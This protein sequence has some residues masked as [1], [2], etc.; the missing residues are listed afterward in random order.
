MSSRLDRLL[1]LLDTGSSTSVR[2]TAAKQLAQL[3]AKSVISD[4]A[5]EEDVKSARPNVPRIDPSGWSELM[6]VVARILPYLHS[7]SHDTRTAASVALSHIFTLV[8]LWC[9][10]P[11]TDADVDMKPP[12]DFPLPEFPLFSVHELMQKGT[13]LLASSGK[14]FIKP[15]GILQS[16]AEVK[17]ARKEAMSRM[18]LD[19]LESVGGTD[20]MDIDK[21]LVA[22]EAEMDVDEVNGLKVE[23]ELKPSPPVDIPE[24]RIKEESS[25]PPRP[26]SKSPSAPSPSTSDAPMTEEDMS[27]LSARERNRLKRKRKPGNN[28]FVAAPPP[29]PQNSS[30]KYSAA[31]AGPSGK[32]RLVAN[33]DQPARPSSRVN[34]PH[35]PSDEGPSDKVVVDPSKG[36]AVSPKAAQQSKALEVQPGCWIWDG[37]VKIL[38][39]D[40][41]S[42]AWEVRHG[43]ALALR[44]LLK[45]QGKYG[46]MR[47]GLSQMENDFAHERWCNDLA[48]RFLCV[49]VLDRFGDFVSDQVVAPVRETVSQTLASLLLHMPRRSVLHVHSILLQMIRQDFTHTKTTNGKVNGSASLVWEV[50]HAGLLG[51]KYEVAVRSDLVEETAV[52]EEGVDQ[53]GTDV[54]RGIVDAAVLG[55]GDRDDDVRSVAAS[56][57]LPVTGPLVK[58][59]PEALSDVLAVLWSCLSDMKDDLSSSV[60]AVM[61]LLGKLVAYDEVIGILADS[62]LSRSLTDLAPTLFAFFRHTISNV[63]LAVVKTLASFMTVTSLPRDWVSAPFLRLLFQN[64]VVEERSD[65]RDATLSAWRTALSVLTSSTGWLENVATQQLLLEWFAIVMT[66]LGVPID[67]NTFYRPFD[68]DHDGGAERHNVDKNMLAQ[69]LSLVTLEIVL[70]ARVS[71]AT[72]LACLIVS[73]PATPADEAFRPI[74]CHYM[75]SPSMLQK[76]LT[77]IVAEE[78]AREHGTRHPS[79]SPLLIERS[80]LARELSTKALAFLQDDPPSAYHEMAFTLA[81]IHGECYHLLQSFAYDCKIPQSS[82]PLLGSEIDITGE[83]PGC[84]TIT[85]AQEAVGPMFARLKESLG[86]TKKREMV[87]INEKRAKVLANIER[88][89]EVKAQYDIRV[90]AAFAAAFV[91]FKST[92]EKVSPVVKGIMNGIKNEDNLDLQTRSAVAVAS[93]I[94]FCAYHKLTQPP[95]KIVKNLCTFLCQDTEQTPTF[96]FNR[97]LTGGV[98]S[99]Q[100]AS[101]TGHT[102]GKETKDE[103]T[104]AEDATK[105]RLSRRGASLAFVQLSSR[106]GSRLLEVIP[107][108]W[109]SM[110]GGLLSA[111]ASGSP[112][113]ADKAIERQYG[114]DVIDS[115]SVLETVV[116][117]LHEDLW[118]RLVDLFPIIVTALRSRFAIV[119]QSAARCFATICEAMTL[120]AMRY[121]IEKVIPLLGDDL[122]LA[123]R[124]G[125]TELIYHIVQKLDIKALP[126][127]LFMVVPVLGRMSDPDD[128]VRAT[129]TNTFASLVKMVPLEAGLPDPPD[130]PEDLLKKRE[131]ERVFLTQLLDGNKVEHYKIPVSI[132]AELRKYQQDGVNWL[133][134]LAKYQ[135]HGILCDDMGLGKTLQS[136]CILASKH[137]ERAKRYEETKSPDSVHLPSLIVCPPTLTG[138]WYYEILKYA[139]NLRPM[140]YTGNARERSR[141]L[142]KFRSHDV[143]I[144]SYEVIRNDISNLQDLHWHFCILDE[145]HIIKN[146]KTKL[147]QAVKRIRA[148][149]RLL[150]SGTPIQ[151]NVLELWSLFDFLMPGF[152]G[153]ESWFNEK[154]SKPILSNRD[155]KAKTGEA[156]ALALEALHK[157]VL[158]FL[159][160]RLKEDVL[161]DLPPKIIQD[162]YCELS[163]LQ[164]HLYDDFSKSQARLAAVD[165][166]KSTQQSKGGEQHVFQSLQYLRK[167]CNHPALVLKDPQAASEALAK[168]TPKSE[169]SDLNDIQHAPKLLALR[170][171]L[172]DCGIGAA[173]NVLSETGKSEMADTVE[174][175]TGAFSQHRALI[176]CQMKQMLD[177]IE[178]DLF[179]KHMP[180]VTYMRLD[181]NTDA[182][183]RHA[184]V[185]T[186]NSDPSIDCLLLTTHVGGLGLT[187]TGADTVI[188]VE[189]DWNP[190]KDL[191]AMDRA[192]RIGQKKVVNVYRLITK[193]TL[194][195]KI[196]GL[197]RFKLNIANSVVTQQNSGLAS[198]DTDL[199]LDLFRRTSEDEDVAAAA[200]RKDKDSSGPAGQ[201]NVLH[202]LEDLPPEED[203]F[204]PGEFCPLFESLH[205]HGHEVELAIQYVGNWN[206]C[207]ATE[208]LNIVVV[209]GGSNP[210]I[211][212]SGPAGLVTC[213]TLLEAATAEYPFDPILFEQEDDIGGT[214]RFRSYENATLVSS[215]QLTS[216]SDFRLPLEHSDH[217]TLEEYVDYLKA[218]VKRF[219]LSERINLGCKVVNISRDPN[220]GH[221]VSYVRRQSDNPNE[222]EEVPQTIHATYLALC[223]GLHVTPAIPQIP[224]IE[225]VLQPHNGVTKSTHV[226]AIFHSVDYKSRS[227]L[228]GRRVMVLGTGET[229]MDLAYEAAKAG[230]KEVVLCSR[231]GFL[232]F[233]KAL[234]DFSLLGFKFESKNPVPIDSLITNLAETAYVHPWVAAS[235]IR[236]FV[237]DFVIKRILWIL[238]GT[239]AG[240]NQWVGELEP[241][242]LGRAY[243]FLNKSHKAMPYINRP[244]RNR[245][246][247]MDYLSRYI[248]PAEDCPPQTDFVVDLAP[249]PTHFLPNGRAVFPL[250]K[251][252]DAIRMADRDVR[253]DTV[254]FATGYTQEFGFLDPESGYG[255]PGEANIRNV[256]KSG[257][258]TVGFIGFVRPGV[259]AIPPI[260]EMQAFFWISLLKNQVKK[261]MPPPNYHLLVKETA[262]IKY[263][264]DHSTY[265]STLAKDIGA[266]PGL[267]EL[268][269]LYGTHVL[270]CYC[271]GAAF[272]P[273]YRLVGPFR[274]KVAPQVIKTEL[275]D[276]ITRRGVMGNLIMGVIPMVFY[277]TVNGLAFVLETQYI[278]TSM[279]PTTSRDTKDGHRICLKPSNGPITALAFDPVSD[280][281]WAG[282]NP[283]NVSAYY[284]PRGMRGVSFPV[285]GDH[286]VKKIVVEDSY[287]RAIA[288][289]NKGLGS[290]SKGGVNKWYFSS[291]STIT[292]FSNTSSASQVFAAANS[293]SDLLFLNALTGNV[294]RQL[295]APSIITHLEFSHTC[296][297]SGSADGCVRALDPRT[298]LR[299]DDGGAESTMKAHISS[300]QALQASGNFV[301]TIGWGLRQG[302]PF[303]DPLVKVYDIRT[304]RPLSPVP[305]S[306]GPAFINL[307]PKRPSSVIVTSNQGLINI[308]DVSNPNKTS[309]FYQ[310]DSPSFVSS[311]AVS[312]TGA[313][314]AFGDADGIV[315]MMTV[316]E[317]DGEVPFNGF[318]G[319]PIEWADTPEPLPHIEWTDSTP[320]NSVGL[321]YYNTLLLS[322]WTPQFVSTKSNFPPPAK[323]PQQVLNTMRISDNVAYAS[324]P[325]ELKGRRNM[326]VVGPRTEQGRFR[327]G[328]GRRNESEPTTPTFDSSI[329]GIP[330]CYRKVEIEYSKFGVEDFDF[331]F[332]NK[333]DYSGLE[334]HILNSYTNPLVQ[335][336]HY[337]LSIRRLAKSHIT[338]NCPREH[339]LLC[340]LGFIVRM[341][342]DAKGINCQASNFCK[343]VGVLAQAQN[344]IEI[345]DYGR[346]TPA[347]N[348]AHMIQSFHRFLI[349]HLSSEGNAF[350]HNPTILTSALPGSGV[351]S[352]AAA[353]ITQ[354]LGIDGKNVITCLTCK[355]VR[356]KDNMT[357]MV[358]M[359]YPR[360]SSSDDSS[361]STD[362]AGILRSS[363]IR[364][365]SHK[366]TCQTCKQFATFESRRSIPSRDLP[367]LLAVN[368]SVYSEESQKF[369]LDSRNHRFLTPTIDLQGQVEGVDDPDVV[370]Y[371]LRSI[372]VQVADKEGSSHLVAIV[373]VPEA[374]GDPELDSPWFVFNDF[375]VRNISE[376]EALSFP[377]QWKLPAIVY[378]ERTDIGERVDFS[379]LHDDSDPTIL[380]HDTNIAVN[381]DKNLVK[382]ECLRYEELPKPGTLVAIDAEFVSMQQEET[383][384]RSDG[385]KKIIRPARL[386]L[387]RVSVLRGDGPKQGI[388]FI[389]DHIHT[390]EAIVDYLT[391]FSGIKFGDLDPHLSRYTLTPLKLVYK[392]LRLL[393]DRGCIF[394]GHGLS[395]DFRI[396]NLFVPPDQVIDTVDLYFIRSRQRRLSLRFLTWFVLKENIQ[397][398]THDSIEDAHAALRLFKA[399]HEFEE[400]GIFDQ[401]LDELY[402]EGKAN[403]WKPPL[404]NLPPS[405]PLTAPIATQPMPA[406]AMMPGNLLQA[407]FAHG[408]GG[409][410]TSHTVTP[411]PMQNFFSSPA[412]AYTQQNWRS[413]R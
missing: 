239:Q 247:F 189:H 21:E 149:H 140:L 350:P 173:P 39:V 129:S 327:S 396:I 260:A 6:A 238:T 288:S 209:G 130:F 113:E 203:S 385:T 107:G 32:A 236:W 212:K 97:K 37:V 198:M 265:M 328:K 316:A 88:Y 358:D 83:K 157:Q 148:H 95:D 412:N 297:L 275:W 197:Q 339:C 72:A 248:D 112:E 125:A 317:H 179:K 126:Y 223:T 161:N 2:A 153:S 85:T 334:T 60:G 82:I 100:G 99:F 196:M 346:D 48:A 199:V 282:S 324:L 184:V 46:G 246:A 96:A 15:T 4:V 360:K 219:G 11:S 217:L 277:L 272:T 91:A 280:T 296:L 20:G 185:Q 172:S 386:S 279:G 62:K 298:G 243:V 160:R 300:I 42:P 59:L 187:L 370:T 411:V 165:V 206:L 182:S 310:L 27:G 359:V 208:F 89:T 158:P 71:A 320:L 361:A 309:E 262:R 289:T 383:E 12:H 135:L 215:K 122:V 235:H 292:T 45:I 70:K 314:L 41:F 374:Q 311:A 110:A 388:P 302:R 104:K 49:F 191:Q 13:L 117:T 389:D 400:K 123:N 137:Y 395:K 278:Q 409:Y 78:W 204:I 65:V 35:S 307:L 80:S 380:C 131:T 230:A 8:P 234:N 379:A 171:L 294:V 3:A 25:R 323:I 245:P 293:Q 306:D 376:D 338:T 54:L 378:L 352:P 151:N 402:K 181:G 118:S 332:F 154:F 136:I 63:R 392:K 363:L 152:L 56:C 258:E 242:R 268:W 351:N 57:L 331:G 372:V 10:S 391:E 256:A 274:S 51:I 69:D 14:E 55:L 134:F 250:S 66:P 273:F 73:W 214:F 101:R 124:Q 159:L 155:G 170:Q 318:E 28:A 156:A 252:K 127:V 144:T 53:T 105:S 390:S 254:I 166:V 180:S 145:G 218:Y 299:R 17:K 356:E 84:F 216:F 183:K 408:A 241:D 120:P 40:L 304:F 373:K 344:A 283:G 249:F 81:R 263:G 79:P 336:M 33:D 43:A 29:P 224:G 375:V 38:E 90:S 333:T 190:M 244:Y 397:T 398:E 371:E 7:K 19:F 222:W 342:E 225:S 150:L 364:Q 186:F 295:S 405:P 47:D 102:N 382:H 164:K 399:Y 232:S 401:R 58:Q 87:I 211:S 162:Y 26:K 176:F 355:A 267:W 201:K 178:Q 74:L 210:F 357:H 9:P 271:F 325:K 114:Q 322:S 229:G 77:A 354:L 36:G 227:Q 202:G 64:L 128:D 226:P 240:C 403:N 1:L 143:V 366:A 264:V 347:L 362:F 393:V 5:I 365:M 75:E 109:H 168:V 349:D 18:G 207:Y 50:R 116:P 381:R 121:V 76:F 231:A 266:A 92:P 384:Y 163:D 119:R 200:K 255:T 253:P 194:E 139:D 52:K 86:R 305:F 410:P 308:V 259:G 228:V 237:S 315:H 337:S 115:L 377:G 404:T 368:A 220:G 312:P 31:T 205:H 340:E 394:I 270:L 23:E 193:G 261:P 276:T 111:C 345:I 251:R 407:T 369:W 16:S 329:E 413:R 233:P 169:T 319:Q 132:K 108:M 303:P 343:T 257:D 68:V 326:V 61:D 284:S 291:P 192:H 22:D 335:V 138:H 348:Y 146:A 353:P 174:T 301:Y 290:W 330:R 133:A 103:A 30:T 321:P 269:R 98:L 34:S 285:G 195:E 141:L 93:F 167:L 341:L 67:T 387:A 313:Y 213:K 367:S 286:G 44:E 287:V 221:L 142:G 147:T 94:E 188:F 175:S 177:I 406:F 281:L 24:I 106:F